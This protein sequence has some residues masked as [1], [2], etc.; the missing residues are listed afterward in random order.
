MRKTD[1]KIDRDLSAA[2]TRVCHVALETV[3]GFAWITHFVNY[4][5]FPR[6]LV[7]V[8]VF[9]TD[10]LLRAACALQLDQTLSDLIETELKAINIPIN[11]KDGQLRCDSE[12]ACER[13]ND[14]DWLQRYRYP[15]LH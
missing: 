9:E 10:E 11:P 3:P 6:S 5:N 2:L 12:E 13:E 7:I 4:Q 15:Q 1:K 14:G 8:S